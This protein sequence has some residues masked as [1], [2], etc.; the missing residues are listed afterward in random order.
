MMLRALFSVLYVSAII[1]VSKSFFPFLCFMVSIPT[2]LFKNS[3]IKTVP[4]TDLCPFGNSSRK[5]GAYYLEPQTNVPEVDSEHV[6]ITKRKERRI[7][8]GLRC[9]FKLRNEYLLK[10]LYGQ[11]PKASRF[12]L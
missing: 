4:I 11:K 3:D 5:T 6:S 1:T 12:S 8:I 9:M 10:F 2:L 7:V